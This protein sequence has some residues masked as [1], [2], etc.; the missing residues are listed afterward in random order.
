MDG[1]RHQ[2]VLF[3]ARLLLFA[4]V[5]HTCIKSSLAF[6]LPTTISSSLLA[7]CC[8]TESSIETKQAHFFF[9]EQLDICKQIADDSDDVLQYNNDDMACRS[10]FKEHPRCTARF[11]EVLQHAQDTAVSMEEYQK[12]IHNAKSIVNYIDAC[13]KQS[14]NIYP[15]REGLLEDITEALT[16]QSIR[17]FRVKQIECD[18]SESDFTPE[19]SDLEILG[20]LYYSAITRSGNYLQE[21]GLTV[22]HCGFTTLLALCRAVSDSSLTY[23]KDGERLDAA[24]SN[25]FNGI[26]APGCRFLFSSQHG[27]ENKV[28]IGRCKRLIVAF[29]SLGNGLVRHEFGGSLAKINNQLYADGLHVDVC[30]VLF[31]ADP[32]QSWYLKDSR[33][34]FDGFE[35]YEQRIR[36]ATRPYKRVSCIGDSMGGSGALLFSHL[37]TE[38]VVAFSPQVDLEGDV[39]VSRYDMTPIIRYRYYKRLLQSVDQAVVAKGINVFV[40]RGVEKSDIR[41]TDL[42][43]SHFSEM[44]SL[45][46]IEHEDCLHHQIAVHLK[47][48]GKLAQVLHSNLVN[49]RRM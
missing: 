34:S 32:S 24:V 38:S 47:Q 22:D 13:M 18:L 40:H 8:A 44:S 31:V 11:G 46:I 35:E 41:H 3:V 25:H 1:Y 12:V 42:L 27:I 19:Q 23:T 36:V 7:H 20:R 33:G 2:V 17:Q 10:R 5:V 39:H 9:N 48:Q 30:D 29:S 4:T 28:T 43:L 37:A 14:N 16:S 26:T 49:N 21:V 15:I 45:Q 6:V